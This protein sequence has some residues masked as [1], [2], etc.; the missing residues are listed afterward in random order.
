MWILKKYKF[1]NKITP[2]TIENMIRYNA[3][4]F[5]EKIYDV[6]VTS[7]SYSDNLTSL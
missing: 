6:I 7:S 4:T 3:L 5:C 2:K 1:C